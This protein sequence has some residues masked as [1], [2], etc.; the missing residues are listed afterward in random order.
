MPSACKPSRRRQ[1]SV[2]LVP[3]ANGIQFKPRLKKPEAGHFPRRLALAPST[4]SPD[5]K[6]VLTLVTSRGKQLARETK[7]CVVPR[8]QLCSDVPNFLRSCYKAQLIPFYEPCH[9]LWHDIQI[10][11]S[12]KDS[13]PAQIHILDSYEYRVWYSRSGDAWYQHGNVPGA[14][15]I[16][17]PDLKK[18]DS[19]K[20]AIHV[21]VRIDRIRRV[22]SQSFEADCSVTT[23]RVNCDGSRHKEWDEVVVRLNPARP[24]TRSDFLRGYVDIPGAGS[25]HHQQQHVRMCLSGIPR[26]PAYTEGIG[27]RTEPFVAI[28]DQGAWARAWLAR[29][30]KLMAEDAKAARSRRVSQF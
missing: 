5:T 15:W 6:H 29:T 18:I 30:K 19:S 2:R 13:E 25:Q 21:D 16:C 24:G 20:A 9:I 3:L 1:P 27:D 22:H 4:V 7:D 11:V 17:C 28:H 26:G 14:K 23:W 8:H 12:D 10:A